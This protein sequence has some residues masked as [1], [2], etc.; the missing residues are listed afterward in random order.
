MMKDRSGDVKHTAATGRI[1][2]DRRW[3]G[4]TRVVGSEELDRFREE[5]EEGTNDPYSVVVNRGKLPIG[6]MSSR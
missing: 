6:L 2:P 1:A 4:N 5:M 3:F